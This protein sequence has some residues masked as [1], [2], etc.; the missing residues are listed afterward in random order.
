VKAKTL[1]KRSLRI[2]NLL[3]LDPERAVLSI[4]GAPR[5]VADCLRYIR[6]S[7]PSGFRLRISSLYPI[8]SDFKS[9]AGSARG[10][11]FHQDL[12]AAKKIHRAGVEKHVDI[13]SR[14]DGFIA[15]LLVFCEVTVIDMLPLESQLPGL[16]FIKDDATHL[17]SFASNSVS[18]LSSLHATEHFGLGRYSDPVDA[19]AH[20]KF[21]RSLARVL[22]V[23]GVLYF[24]VPIGK[25][26]VMFNAHRIFEP[27][28]IP[29]YFPGLILRSFSFV[30]D[31]GDL[32]QELGLDQVPEDLEYGCGLFEFVKTTPSQND[33]QEHEP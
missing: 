25:Q 17:S 30:D 21:M 5:F 8:L 3:G 13:G 31:R 29:A 23:G 27:S 2:L 15:H 4:I 22:T 1:L 24:S 32:I 28:S 14:I 26:C 12:W 10:H 7:P 33:K 9:Q 6:Q 16:T 20:E 11:Y 18:S 19:F